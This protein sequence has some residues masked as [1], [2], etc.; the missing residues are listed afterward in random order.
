VDRIMLT[1]ALL[2]QGFSH[3]DLGCLNR[4]GELTHL[5]RG[6]YSSTASTDLSR[7]DNHRRPIRAPQL[8]DGSVVSHGSA[9]VLHGLPV[10]EAAIERVHITRS[11][12]GHG[13]RRTLVHA[14]CAPLDEIDLVLEGS[15]VGV[16]G[17][18]ARTL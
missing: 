1:Q 13:K 14:H 10:W 16:I 8:T 17:R 5:R 3:G 4:S 9:A 2:A 15:E 6:A 18:V 12:R 11:R 7:E